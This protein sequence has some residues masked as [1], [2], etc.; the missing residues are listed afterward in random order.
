M[1]VVELAVFGSTVG[2]TEVSVEVVV[3][4]TLALVSVEVALVS[5]EVAAVVEVA[6]STAATG[7]A[8]PLCESL[9]ARNQVPLRKPR[10]QTVQRGYS[11][12]RNGLGE[13]HRNA[14]TLCRRQDS[15][16]K[17]EE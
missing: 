11:G 15:A 3:G 9:L 16:P 17:V 2:S 1:T 12:G 7:A 5:V 14:L 13:N 4:S 10:P 6:G 8:A